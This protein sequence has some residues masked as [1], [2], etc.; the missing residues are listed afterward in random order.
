MQEASQHQPQR[1]AAL[2][3]SFA[4]SHSLKAVYFLTLDRICVPNLILIKHSLPELIPAVPASKWQLSETGQL[5]CKTLAEKIEPYSPDMVFS[6]IEPKAIETAQIVAKHINKTCRTFENLHEHNRTGVDFVSKEVFETSVSTFFK[7]PEK[8]VF[9]KETAAQAHERF[10]K[11]IALLVK[12]YQNK[13]LA[14][15]AHGTVITLFVAQTAG[16]EPFTFWKK[17]GLPSFVVFSLPQL[18]LITV[19][20]NAF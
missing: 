15:V 14:V 19:V 6:S 4:V 20:E 10:S 11:A 12:K 5:R 9:G 16:L 2:P 13:N 7:S 8:L 18:E 17:L 1:T 3:L